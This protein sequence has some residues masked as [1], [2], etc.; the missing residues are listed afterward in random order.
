MNLTGDYFC[1]SIIS[2]PSLLTFIITCRHD[3]I[4]T[5]TPAYEKLHSAF[6]FIDNY[7]RGMQRAKKIHGCR[8][9]ELLSIYGETGKCKTVYRGK[10]R[11]R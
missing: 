5:M 4:N 8:Q 10:L 2:R 9:N 6:Y 7:F 3:N 11:G 1:F